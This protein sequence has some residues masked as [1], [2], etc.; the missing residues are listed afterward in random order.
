M[1]PGKEILT[2][3]FQPGRFLQKAT[4]QGD[5]YKKQPGKEIPTKTIKPGRFLQKATRQG[6]SYKNL[7]AREIPTKS[8]QARRFLQNATRQGDSYKNLPAR[9]IATKS[10]QAH[11]G[12]GLASTTFCILCRRESIPL[13]ACVLQRKITFE[14]GANSRENISENCPILLCKIIMSNSLQK[15]GSIC[16]ITKLKS[17]FTIQEKT[18]ENGANSRSKFTSNCH[19]HVNRTPLRDSLRNLD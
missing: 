16:S 4:R 19:A 3:T 18:F 8:N 1:Q 2:K 6:D 11:R 13:R 5:S 7:Q 12:H 15:L 9:E 10:N 17:F 14:G